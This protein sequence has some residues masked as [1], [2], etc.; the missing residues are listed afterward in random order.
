MLAH[1]DVLG[2]SGE[3]EV[4]ETHYRKLCQYLKEHQIPIEINQLGVM[5]KR[6][7]PNEW[8]LKLAGE[9]GCQAIIGCDA[10]APE[11]LL[12]NSSR[13]FCRQIANRNNLQII[14]F[15]PGFLPK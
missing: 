11:Q 1:P 10:H 9:T 4:Y 6:H 15:F 8:F 13:E 7:Y 2:F 3:R 14:D 5:S 12:E